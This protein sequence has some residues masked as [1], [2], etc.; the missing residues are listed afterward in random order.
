VAYCAIA[1]RVAYGVARTRCPDIFAGDQPIGRALAACEE[2]CEQTANVFLLSRSTG[3]GREAEACATAC[4]QKCRECADQAERIEPV[5]LAD[6]IR[7]CREA[8]QACRELAEKHRK[9]EGK[10]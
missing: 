10:G 3:Y 6:L 9:R 4:A 2:L 7:A 8:A 5:R 1:V